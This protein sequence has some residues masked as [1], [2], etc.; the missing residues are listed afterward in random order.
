M[1]DKKQNYNDQMLIRTDQKEM[2][3]STITKE[4]LGFSTSRTAMVNLMMTI[5]I[6]HLHPKYKSGNHSSISEFELYEALTSFIQSDEK[7]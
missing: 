7:K 5:W 3:D 2:F 4:E 1:V 6:K